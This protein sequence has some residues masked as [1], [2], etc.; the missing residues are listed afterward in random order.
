MPPPPVTPGGPVP[1]RPPGGAPRMLM[2]V[3]P[4]R[5]FRAV[6]LTVSAER[7]AD[8]G[9]LALWVG[10]RHAPRPGRCGAVA[11]ALAA[12]RAGHGD[13][14]DDARRRAHRDGRPAV[15]GSA[16]RPARACGT[17]RWALRVRPAVTAVARERPARRVAAPLG[18]AALVVEPGPRGA[19]RLVAHAPGASRV[20]LRGDLTAWRETPLERD[21]DAW[22][23]PAAALA[24]PLAPGT[25]RVSVRLDDGPWR[26]P[27][28][29]PAV[30]D[31]FASRVGLLVVP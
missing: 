4:P 22:L 20:A 18:E 30:D 5:A 10:A 11:R 12:A 2:V 17:C 31:D 23:L 7:R 6:D 3:P 29:L 26:P 24:L 9:E 27:A 25:Y 28:N 14:L 13:A 15:R 1:V 8:V 19:R 16:A 21:G